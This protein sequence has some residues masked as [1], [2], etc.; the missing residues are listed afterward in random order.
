MR[1]PARRPSPPIDQ[2]LAAT[3]G[4]Q[5]GVASLPFVEF[6]ARCAFLRWEEYLHFPIPFFSSLIEV[7]VSLS[8]D[9]PTCEILAFKMCFQLLFSLIWYLSTEQPKL[10]FKLKLLI[11][12]TTYKAGMNSMDGLL[13]KTPKI[14]GYMLRAMKV[15]F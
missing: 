10:N 6:V 4:D 2:R 13:S 7:F 1:S 9:L 8:D 14:G 5:F 12:E 11:E 3:S 15:D